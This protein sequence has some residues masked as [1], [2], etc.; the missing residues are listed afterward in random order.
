MVPLY[1][2]ALMLKEVP[3]SLFAGDRHFRVGIPHRFSGWV[4]CQKANSTCALFD[5]DVDCCGG[6]GHIRQCIRV[7]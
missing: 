3:P 1:L 4:S 6:N 5:N 7:S 2:A